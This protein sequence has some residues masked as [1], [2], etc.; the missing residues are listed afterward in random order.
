LNTFQYSSLQFNTDRYILIEFDKFSTVRIS[1][2]QFSSKQ[3]VQH[4]SIKF[5]TNQKSEIQLDQVSYHWIELN[6][7]LYGEMQI[8]FN[9]AK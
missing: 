5:Y 4:R 2:V 3:L 8:Q 6:T 7:N 9:T 1:S